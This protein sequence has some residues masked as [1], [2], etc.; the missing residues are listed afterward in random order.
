MTVST[1]APFQK[2]TPPNPE[3]RDDG[4]RQVLKGTRG[5]R[6]FKQ[7]GIFQAGINT[8]SRKPEIPLP[9]I[10]ANH[11]RPKLKPFINLKEI[12][13]RFQSLRWPVETR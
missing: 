13:S 8:P 1:A 11:L 6:Y 9:V 5:Q 12:S 10:E 3:G 2:T 7:S 4:F